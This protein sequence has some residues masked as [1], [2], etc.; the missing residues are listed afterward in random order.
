MTTSSEIPRTRLAPA[1]ARPSALFIEH[2][3]A[4]ICPIV[5]A[6]VERFC[7]R[8]GSL[9][10]DLVQIGFQAALH[11]LAFVDFE[12]NWRGFVK[13]SV[14]RAMRDSL[15]QLSWVAGERR[16]DAVDHYTPEVSLLR[17][18]EE[19]ERHREKV[20]TFSR[21]ERACRQKL[22]PE[23]QRLFALRLQ[24]PPRLSVMIRNQT[25]RPTV[26]WK[27]VGRYMG[28]SPRRLKRCRAQIRRLAQEAARRERL[29][30]VGSRRPLRGG[31]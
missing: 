12:R 29:A 18:E 17:R 31:R 27:V 28:L 23:G 8:D 14:R 25:G 16:E 22:T 26:T 1:S 24:P 11:S 15:D 3:R 30:S 21:T 9:R 20:M 2:Y 7:D 13:V 19:I 10:Q 5:F 6:A 4:T